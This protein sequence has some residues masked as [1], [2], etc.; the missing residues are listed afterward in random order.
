MWE[1]VTEFLY[2]TPNGIQRC[3]RPIALKRRAEDAIRIAS[4]LTL[5]STDITVKY[6]ARQR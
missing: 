5:C 2:S 1:I 4:E 3:T 6:Y